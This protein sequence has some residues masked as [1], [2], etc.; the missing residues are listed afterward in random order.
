MAQR[1]IKYMTRDGD[2]W[3]LL[4]WQM[5]GDAARYADIIAANPSVAIAPVLPVGI[6]LYVPVLAAAAA[7]PQNLPPWTIAAMRAGTGA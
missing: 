2:R 3:D 4:A 1:F 6:T 5:Y 7:T